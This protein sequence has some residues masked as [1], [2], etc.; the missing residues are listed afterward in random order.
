MYSPVQ[1]AKRKGFKKRRLTDKTE[2]PAFQD[3]R[4]EEIEAS[5]KQLTS[6]FTSEG[7][8]VICG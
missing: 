8:G 1:Q 3:P 6:S 4:P 2:V 5:D 7:R